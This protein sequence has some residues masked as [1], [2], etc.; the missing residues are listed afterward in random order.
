LVN[1]PSATTD[2]NGNTGGALS[3]DGSLEQYMSIAGGG[4][5][6]NLQAGT[7]STWVKWTGTQDA[8]FNSLSYGNVTA[9]D[10]TF[11]SNQ[12]LGLNGTS[13]ATAKLTWQPYTSAAPAIVGTTNVGNDVWRH[14]A[15]SYA[16]G[17]HQLYL[18]GV[19]QG[20]SAAAGTI[21]NN[22]TPLTVGAW[23]GT[24]NGHSTS[25]IDDLAVFNS[26]LTHQQVALLKFNG[27]SPQALAQ[28]QQLTGVLSQA[29]SN[30]IA[31][32][33]QR[34]G[35]RLTDGSGLIADNNGNSL[36]QHSNSPNSTMWLTAAS[37]PADQRWVRFDL[38]GQTALD[39]ARVWNYNE[40]LILNRQVA[41]ALV[42]YSVDGINWTN[43]GS[44]PTSF[45]TTAT[46]TNSYDDVT[47]IQFGGVTA[48]YV[49]FGNPANPLVSNNVT[50]TYVGLS[51]VQFFGTPQSQNDYLI[52]AD[53]VAAS[54]QYSGRPA[55]NTINASGL[56]EVSG[57]NVPGHTSTFADMWLSDEGGAMPWIR[58]DVTG[59]GDVLLSKML[60]WNYN[61]APL[62]GNDLTSRGVRTA[63]IKYAS[64]GF[65]GNLSDPNDPAWITLA[66]NVDFTRAD[67]HSDYQAVDG[68][69][70][71]A[72][73]RY[74]LV[75]VTSNYGDSVRTGLSEVQFFAV[76]PEPSS[77]AMFAFGAISLWLFRRKNN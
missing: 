26:P 51:E 17:S 19:L 32:G 31:G 58:F 22:A 23:K 67:A 9:R 11:S 48:R 60:A 28:V 18:D 36:P 56:G 38:G 52:S 76:V 57:S 16:S 30:F 73:L 68:F 35:K 69:H 65:S 45:K 43:L 42:Q 14:V 54:S 74:V 53:S 8:S 3:F 77:L 7:I 15:V 50:F 46:G 1:G 40:A 62:S 72:N 12:I 5:L 66:S 75:Q 4:G 61:E 47:G 49:R 20:S 71:N 29:S 2:R 34:M 25:S 13:P 63:N 27:T 64:D 70:F 37:S 21:A 33:S 10:D 39:S 59:G 24:G 6:D 41:E 44:G 55:A